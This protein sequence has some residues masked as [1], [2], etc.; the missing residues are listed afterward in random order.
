M[1]FNKNSAL[2][3]AWVSLVVSDTFKKEQVPKLFN[4][5][6][7]VYEILGTLE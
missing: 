4:L 5:R 6:D 1:M 7:V 2:V 3:K